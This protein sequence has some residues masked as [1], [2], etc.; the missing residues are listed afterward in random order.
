M[1][2]SSAEK[3]DHACE[4]AI[5]AI[6]SLQFI[7]K[8]RVHTTFIK[9]IYSVIYTIVYRYDPDLVVREMDNIEQVKHHNLSKKDKL[10]SI[11]TPPL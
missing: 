7:Q 11:A 2:S 5:I 6:R 4:S 10:S 1:T 8:S 9:N 3:F